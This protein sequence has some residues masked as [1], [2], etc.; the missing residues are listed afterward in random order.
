[1]PKN[2]LASP[3]TWNVLSYK[4]TMEMFVF[5]SLLQSRCYFQCKYPSR[6][7]CSLRSFIILY[8]LH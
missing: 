7:S 1:M 5:R 6:S 8:V 4:N 3:R 2:T